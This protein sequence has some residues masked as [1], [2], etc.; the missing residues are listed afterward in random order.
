MT[1]LAY[2]VRMS[3]PF[4]PSSYPTPARRYRYHRRRLVYSLISSAYFLPLF[5]IPPLVKGPLPAALAAISAR[6]LA[7]VAHQ[8]FGRGKRVNRFERP[9]RP[10][11]SHER[12]HLHRPGP[13]VV[14]SGPLEALPCRLSERQPRMQAQRIS[15]GHLN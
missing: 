6:A 15:A 3:E 11:S 5:L 14:S 10:S 13:F 2:H 7:S 8:S 4:Q 1:P 12:Q 9:Y